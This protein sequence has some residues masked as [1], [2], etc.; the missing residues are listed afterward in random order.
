M[1]DLDLLE[2]VAEVVRDAS[3]CGL[4]KTAA[5]PVLSTLRHFRDEY[6][7]HVQGRT[8]PAGVCAA[9]RHYTIDP[10]KCKGCGRCAK[11]CPAGAITGELKKPYVIDQDKCAHCG[12]CVETCRFGAVEEK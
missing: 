12:A 5:N 2:E 6:L 1:E 4:G 10:D 9:F 3:L 11:A 7:A 8:C